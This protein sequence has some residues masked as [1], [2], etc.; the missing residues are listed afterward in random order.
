MMGSTIFTHQSCTVETEDHMQ[1][2]QRHIMD[3]VVEGPLGKST[4]DITE[5]YKSVFGHTAREGHRMSLGN[6][7]IEGALRHLLHHDI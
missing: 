2:Q 5:R 1:V 7:N 4:V 6:A 3:D